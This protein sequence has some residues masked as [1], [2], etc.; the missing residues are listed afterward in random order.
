MAFRQSLICLG[1]FICYG[2]GRGETKVGER[3]WHAARGHQG[4]KQILRLQLSSNST[5]VF[6]LTCPVCSVSSLLI[7]YIKKNLEKIHMLRHKLSYSTAHIVIHCAE[8]LTCNWRGCVH[9]KC[10]SQSRAALC[11]S[12]HFRCHI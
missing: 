1:F 8:V 5:N 12:S 11:R 3:G 4:S 9:R 7:R 2:H 6:R 10:G